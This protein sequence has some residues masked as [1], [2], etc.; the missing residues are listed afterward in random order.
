MTLT[1][2]KR[3]L[4]MLEAKANTEAC[5]STLL[6]TVRCIS[7]SALPGQSLY[8]RCHCCNN[9]HCVLRSRCYTNSVT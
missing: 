5:P 7:G 8:S 3:R 9:V 1:E 2:Y 4:L 6:P